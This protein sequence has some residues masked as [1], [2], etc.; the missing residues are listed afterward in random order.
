MPIAWGNKAKL[1]PRLPIDCSEGAFIF[2]VTQ[3]SR[4]AANASHHVLHEPRSF[5]QE[6]E[7]AGQRLLELRILGAAHRA[8]RSSLCSHEQRRPIKP[9]NSQQGSVPG[10]PTHG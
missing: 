2:A 6:C 3:N 4:R 7:N 8:K 1:R 10:L 9:E 5:S